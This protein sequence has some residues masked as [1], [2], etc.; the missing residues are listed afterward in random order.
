MTTQIDVVDINNNDNIVTTSKAKSRAKAPPVKAEPEEIKQ[1]EDIPKA[2]AKS[3][4]RAKAPPVKVE[5]EEVKQEE[6]TPKPKAKSKSRAKASPVKV[7]PEEEE[8]EEEE[9][10]EEEAEEEAVNVEPDEVDE[11]KPKYRARPELK[12]KADCPDC[13]KTLTQHGLKYTH[14]RYCKAKQ[15]TRVEPPGLDKPIPELHH[16]PTQKR[17]ESLFATSAINNPTD[18]QISAYLLTQKRTRADNK[19]Q[20]MSALVSNA[21]LK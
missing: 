2:K 16:T 20:H 6:D 15:P 1:E 8:V 12:E 17:A 13:G 18:E 14:A 21:L 19:R 7:E 5:P 9:V 3:K 10:E 4:S 11:T